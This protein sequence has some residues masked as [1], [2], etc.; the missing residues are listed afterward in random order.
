[1]LTP[2][3]HA[4]RVRPLLMLADTAGLAVAVW[5]AHLIRFEPE[6]LAPKWSQLVDSPG[7]ILWSAL[8][9]WLLSAAAELYEPDVVHRFWEAAV[10][11]TVMIAAWSTGLVLATWAWP[12][13]S[14][15]RGLLVLTVFMWTP[16]LL[17]GRLVFASWLRRRHRRPA[18]VVGQTEDVASFCRDLAAHP[19]AP[20]KP[21]DGAHLPLADVRAKVLETGARLIVVAGSDL[22]HLNRDLDHELPTLH[23]SGVPV[24]AAVDLWA[25]LEERLPIDSLSPALFLHQP[26]FGAI[27]WHPFHRVAAFLDLLLAALFL[28]LAA[29]IL[30]VAGLA[31]LLSDGAPVIYRQRR[32]GQFG[33]SFECLKLRTM[34]RDAEKLGPTFAAA[35][36]PRSIPVGRFLR[37]FRIDEL[38][39]LWNVLRGEMAI[40][41]PRPERP[42]FVVDLA[43]QIPFYTF[44]LAVR[45][46]ITGW[47]Q[48]NAPYARDLEGHRRKLEFDLY[49]IR[50]PSLQLYLLT[51]L[52]T[53]SAVLVGSRRRLAA[54]GSRRPSPGQ[55]VTLP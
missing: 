45:P 54:L 23:F 36:D 1:M 42:E 40:A 30:L 13:W 20:W 27:H 49:Y 50:E 26:G 53:A 35:D 41:G 19:A 25:G 48:V 28:L 15:G 18:L 24:V 8:S 34:V 52:R 22:E 21:I 33:R 6:W 2:Q 38:P 4:P 39:Q 32:I 16:F 51:L 43:R 29:P 12:A 9:C 37:R 17:L 14:F 7:L 5:L 55:T 44:R 31:V 11:V 47:A 46:G 10:R 3:A